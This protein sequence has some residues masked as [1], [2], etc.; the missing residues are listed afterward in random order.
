[1]N[2]VGTRRGLSA[3]VF[4]FYFVITLTNAWFGGGPTAGAMWALAG[5]YGAALFG[6]AAGFFWARW[7]AV[8]TGLFGVIVAVVGCWQLRALEPVF[9]FVGGT[10]LLAVFA[11]WGE[12]MSGPFDGQLAW[13]EKFHMDENA[14]QRL[15][16]SVIRAGVSLPFVLLY[17][18]MPKPD[19][20]GLA[21]MGLAILG[22]AGLVKMRTWGLLALGAAGLAMIAGGPHELVAAD[23]SSVIAP[24]ARVVA[25]APML[26]GA[27][28]LASIASFV[29]PM[30]RWI[31][32]R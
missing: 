17:A 20:L 15:G 9:V 24:A 31:A 12:A 2:L 10:H 18:L 27:L 30:G 4:A 13:R 1:M 22:T 21:A 26:V 32:A 8:G 25:L 14:V 7:Y 3:L 11:L 29:R 6:I 5:C 19:A 16:R 23:S 28:L